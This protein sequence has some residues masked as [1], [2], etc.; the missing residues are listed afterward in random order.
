MK[1]VF[2]HTVIVASLLLGNMAIAPALSETPLATAATQFEVRVYPQARINVDAEGNI[3]SIWNVTDGS[4]I[5]PPYLNIYQGNVKIGM[6]PEIQVELDRISPRINWSQGGL[7]YQQARTASVKMAGSEERGW[8]DFWISSP[9]AQPIAPFHSNWTVT[10]RYYL[11]W[12]HSLGF[13]YLVVV[14]KFESL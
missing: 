5:P 9:F 12:E 3:L 2:W 13:P 6:T 1:T 11:K 7:I 10:H 8:G 14:V 4:S